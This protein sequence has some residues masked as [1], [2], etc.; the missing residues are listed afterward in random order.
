MPGRAVQMGY[1]P[2]PHRAAMPHRAGRP[3]PPRNNAR[4]GISGRS[5]ILIAAALFSIFILFTCGALGLGGALIYGR[6]V[7][8]GVRSLGVDLGGMSETEA[9]AA[10]RTAAESLTLTDPGTGRHWEVNPVLLGLIIDVE[11]T[12]QGAYAQGRGSGD[13]IKALSGVDVYP[14]VTVN[15]QLA[16]NGLTTLRDQLEQPARNAGVGLVDGRV[17]QTAPENG[18]ALDIAATVAGLQTNPSGVLAD[19]V[20][21]LVMQTTTPSVTDASGLVAAA[22]ALLVN[23]LT[24]R[25]FDP[26][27]GDIVP[28]QA[29]P[30]T[31]ARWL[32][33]NSDSGSP[34]G[35]RLSLDE[36]ELTAF[37]TGQAAALDSSR[38]LKLADAVAD[39]QEAIAKNQTTATVRVYHHDTQHIVQ[40]GETIISIAYNYGVPYPWVQKANGWIED[41]SIGQEIVIPSADNFFDYE[42]VADKRIEVSISQQRTRVYENGAIKWDWVSST[43]ISSSPTWPGVYQVISHVPNAYAANWNLYMPQFMGVYRPIPGQD[44][45]NGFHGFPTRGG[46]Q[47]LW[48]NS[49]GTKVTYGCILLSNA[50]AQLLYDWAQEG[51]VVEILP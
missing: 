22:E 36:R 24:V 40:P 17:T 46:G 8:P 35:L 29:A 23:P 38:Y 7:L 12:A 33:A 14:V 1:V 19:G 9:I 48:E 39:V 44:F 18:R 3:L 42:P 6:G 49:L 47:L 13:F 27:T 25:A 30:E 10:L 2:P 31:W 51:V 43:G 15:T 41:I 5:I 4:R 28:W 34:T 32:I 26:V 16:T 45:T 37:L 21:E 11:K 20:L 50:N